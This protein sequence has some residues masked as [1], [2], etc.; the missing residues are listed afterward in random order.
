MYILMLFD[1]TFYATVYCIQGQ[2][3]KPETEFLDIDQC[4][5]NM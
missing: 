4:A 1:L 2:S 3:S 5:S